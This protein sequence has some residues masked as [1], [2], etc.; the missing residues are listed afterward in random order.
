MLYDRSG[1]TPPRSLGAFSGI[2]MNTRVNWSPDSQS[3]VF[4]ALTPAKDIWD[5]Q[6][7]EL[8]LVE[9]LTGKTTQLTDNNFDDIGP[10]I[11][12]DGTKILYNCPA[13]YTT[14][15]RSLCIRQPGTSPH[16][17]ARDLYLYAAQPSWSPDGEW[18]AAIAYDPNSGNKGVWIVRPNGTDAQLVAVGDPGS[19]RDAVDWLP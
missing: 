17:V 15:H 19:D 7:Q 3:V 5:R 11:S 6:N 16:V 4:N 9:T 1:A 2:D 18:I 14:P 12:P 13:E 8:W 10:A